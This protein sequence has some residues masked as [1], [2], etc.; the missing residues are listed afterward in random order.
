MNG[1]SNTLKKKNRSHKSPNSGREFVGEEF[2]LNPPKLIS[3]T[4]L[5]NIFFLDLN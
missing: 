4:L 3:P 5:F 2:W 1:I